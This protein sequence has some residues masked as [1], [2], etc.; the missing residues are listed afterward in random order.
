MRYL[1][2][3]I[4]GP[5]KGRFFELP[6]NREIL[7]GSAFGKDTQMSVQHFSITCDGQEFHLRDLNSKTGTFLYGVDISEVESFG[8]EDGYQ[9]VAGQT[10]FRVCIEKPSV[11]GILRK[12]TEPLF[13][14]VDASRDEG[15]LPLLKA[16]N[17]QYQSLFEGVRAEWLEEFAPYLVYLPK[18]SPLLEKLVELG[19]G[20]RWGIY[21]TSMRPFQTLVKHMQQFLWVK[22]EAGEKLYFRFYDPKT[23]QVFLFISNPK[24]ANEVFQGISSYLM[25]AK[26]PELLIKFTYG[27]RGVE[28]Q[29]FPVFME[30]NKC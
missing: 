1:L 21:F 16:S 9:F 3:I 30:K 12:Q 15:I 11:L 27:Q 18:D 17:N 7:F 13:A 4:D 20:N 6:L 24:Q 22:T 26:K 8:L 29:S 10:T 2:E 19:W 14:I 5:C 25:K 28:L 23:L